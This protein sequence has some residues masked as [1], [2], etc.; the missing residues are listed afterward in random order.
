MLNSC[1][2][3]RIIPNPEALPPANEFPRES[4]SRKK[5]NVSGAKLRL[6]LLYQSMY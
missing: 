3:C 6:L 2:E 1:R 4:L 5:K